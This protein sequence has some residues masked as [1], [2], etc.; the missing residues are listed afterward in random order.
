MKLRHLLTY[1]LASILAVAA[2]PAAAQVEGSRFT[3]YAGQ[4]DAAAAF[5]MWA[6][7]TADLDRAWTRALLDTVPTSS[8]ESKVLDKRL[9]MPDRCLEDDRLLLDGKEL[10]MSA[11]SVRGEIARS[12]LLRQAKI[13]TAQPQPGAASA[14]LLAHVNGLP[15]NAKVDRAVL[16]GHDFAACLA[17]NQWQSVRA[18]VTAE[19]NSAAEATALKAMSP[20]FSGC[21]AA[22]AKLNLNKPLLRLLLSEAAYHALTYAPTSAQATAVATPGTSK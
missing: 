1:G 20:A 17:D 18:F 16:I 21:M 12:L 19:Y 5:R 11:E 15:A 2:A 6:S 22:G 3:R 13:K 7:C 4:G 14:W 9:G 8:D 10:V